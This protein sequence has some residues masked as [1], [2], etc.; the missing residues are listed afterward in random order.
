M[1]EIEFVDAQEMHLLHPE[2]FEVPTQ[3]E[4]DNIQPGDS[5]KVCVGKERFWV[6]VELIG[7]LVGMKDVIGGII[8]N[9]LVFT[10]EHG[11]KCGDKIKFEKKNIYSI[12][13]AT[14]KYIIEEELK[15]DEM[16]RQDGDEFC[17]FSLEVNS[18]EEDGMYVRICSYDETKKHKDFS[19]LIGKKVRVT[20]EVIN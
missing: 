8:D 3:E 6:T 5:V 9:D 4:L 10:H 19:K 7:T 14:P 11:L 12:F 15:I 17:S 13:K 16:E 20:I 1:K 18:K 2:T